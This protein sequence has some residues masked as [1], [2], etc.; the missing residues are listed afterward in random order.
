MFDVK[1]PTGR[2]GGSLHGMDFTGRIFFNFD[3]FDVWRIYSTL[4]KASQQ[5]EFG[6]NVTW[7][8]FLVDEIDPEARLSPKNR[9]LAACAAVRSAHPESHQR[10]VQALL[11]MIYQ[12]RDDPKKD[13]T[14]AVAARVAGI[15]GDE[16]I[17]GAIDPGLRLLIESSEVARD[18]GVADV[19]TIVRNGPALH[20]KTT[21]AI[22]YGNAVTHLDLIDRMLRDDGVWEM[23]KPPMGA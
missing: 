22:N 10:F 16:V 21:G 6:A 23:T 17:A 5:R 19:P 3:N 11:T 20:I 4:L 18:L 1:N 8:E 2:D 12:E 14:L 7:E 15:D 9:V 13:T